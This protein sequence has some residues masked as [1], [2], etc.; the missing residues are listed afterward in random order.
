MILRSHKK[1]LLLGLILGVLLGLFNRP[2]DAQEA[3]L[4][5]SV[6][7]KRMLDSASRRLGALERDIAIEMRGVKRENPHMKPFVMK[8]PSLPPC[9]PERIGI[10][11]SLPAVLPAPLPD[12]I[13]VAFLNRQS[14]HVYQHIDLL[15]QQIHQAVAIYGENTD[16]P[17]E[18][19]GIFAAYI[20][21]YERNR[22]SAQSTFKA[23]LHQVEHLE[24]SVLLFI[25]RYQVA[26]SPPDCH[27]VQNRNKQ[28]HHVDKR[29]KLQQ[30]RKVQSPLIQ[31]WSLM[32][33]P[34]L[35][36]KVRGMVSHSE[37]IDKAHLSL[38]WRGLT[39]VEVVP[40]MFESP[41]AFHA[42]L[43]MDDYTKMDEKPD[44]E[45]KARYCPKPDTCIDSAWEP[46][47]MLI[48]KFYVGIQ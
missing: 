1:R 33:Y 44:I 32:V 31:L 11:Q 30:A 14:T 22:R 3:A 6:D 25:Q 12:D 42:V 34:D 39:S 13:P 47:S 15:K 45:V 16:I 40:I 8:A 36:L 37:E 10:P 4:Y 21:R 17:E 43:T 48:I 41:N 5:Y 2:A 28:I 9:P 23:L 29:V 20:K 38:V 7:L 18:I 27:I 46:L 19:N 35:S 24:N 26:Q